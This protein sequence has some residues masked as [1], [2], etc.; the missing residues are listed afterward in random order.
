MDFFST[1]LVF[2]FTVSIIVTFHEFGHYIAA[3]LCGVKV[4]E[5]SV[6]FG[7]KMFGKKFGKD[8]T[9]YKVCCLPLGGYVK[10][11]D[12]RE[13]DVEEFEKKKAFNN[14][15]RH[16]RFFI[17]FAGPL[18]NF[19]LAIF[20]YLVIFMNGYSGFQPIAS[21][22]IDKSIAENIGMERNDLIYAVNNVEV[23]TWSDLKLQT[24]KFL[25]DKEDIYFEVISNNKKRK[26][27]KVN[28]EKISLNNQNI[29]QQIGILN[30]ISKSV[31]IGYIEKN[32]PA[33]NIGLKIG[34][35]FLQVD[36]KKIENWNQ[37]VNII[38]ANPGKFIKLNI[39]RD[40]PLI[41]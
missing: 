2:I 23:R 31:D 34:D 41:V 16:K 30:F 29:L 17:V 19:I 40:N 13:G 9:E 25:S 14:Q 18:F 15:E 39:Q 3:R 10:M 33:E 8:N 21:I 38:E 5:F 22:V 32:S 7:K 36:D 6:G 4:L 11:L 1:V 26:L 27:D 28:Y 24:V 20:F 35:K 37:L 12:E